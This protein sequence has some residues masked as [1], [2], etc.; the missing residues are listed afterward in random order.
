MTYRLVQAN[1]ELKKTVR[2]SSIQLEVVGF[3]SKI[4]RKWIEN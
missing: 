3:E 2:P 4:S 1:C